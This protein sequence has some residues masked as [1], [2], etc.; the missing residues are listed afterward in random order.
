MIKLR[1]ATT[2]EDRE[3]IYRLRY[4]LYVEDQGLFR[5]EAD[6]ENRLL[7]D[8]YDADSHLFLAELDGE[9]VG[10]SRLTLGSDATF[11][12]ETRRAYDF[13]RFRGVVADEDFAMVT[14]LCVRRAHRGGSLGFR[15]LEA[16]F[17]LAAERSA[18]IILGRCCTGLLKHY[19]PFG[20]RPFGDLVKDPAHG[21]RARIAVVLGDVDYLRR[22]NS[23]MTTALE[24]RTKPAPDLDRLLACLED[25]SRAGNRSIPATGLPAFRP[26]QG[27]STVLKISWIKSSD[28]R[29]WA[30]AS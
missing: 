22:M 2:P 25:S 8:S 4:E 12:E 21:I 13:E 18:E 3:A 15:L 28:V 16:A 14:R 17:G 6:H 23:P 30:S 5:D 11:T 10:T 27:T 19:R 24:R 26:A 20:Y 1:P 29:S 7:V 9:I